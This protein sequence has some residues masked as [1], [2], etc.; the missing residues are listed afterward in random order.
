[1]QKHLGAIQ[2]FSYGDCNIMIKYFWEQ[3]SVIF[4]KQ[5][6]LQHYLSIIKLIPPLRIHYR[7]NNQYILKIYACILEVG[8]S[9]GPLFSYSWNTKRNIT[10]SL[11]WC[12][13]Y[14]F[15]QIE[16]LHVLQKYHILRDFLLKQCFKWCLIT[17]N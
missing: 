7:Q 16:K 9:M 17:N 2:Y 3:T 1:M 12:I 13:G 10:F 11:I 4:N 5:L 14:V 8:N 6:V 15:Q